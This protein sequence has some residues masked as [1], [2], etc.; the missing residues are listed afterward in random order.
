MDKIHIFYDF[1]PDVQN[2]QWERRDIVFD[3][4]KDAFAWVRRNAWNA[5]VRNIKEYPFGHPNKS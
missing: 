5:R 4:A 2:C 3:D 1:I